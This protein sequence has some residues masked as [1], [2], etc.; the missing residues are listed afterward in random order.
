MLGGLLSAVHAT[1]D[2]FVPAV[3]SSE[4]CS[5]NLQVLVN[6]FHVIFIQNYYLREKIFTEISEEVIRSYGSY[7]GVNYFF[8]A[9]LPQNVH[10]KF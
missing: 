5:V 2:C 4:I 9:Q 1:E 7:E 6:K 10:S 8:E 3:F